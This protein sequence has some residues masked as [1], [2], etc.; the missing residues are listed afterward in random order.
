LELV[1]K[2][3]YLFV[4]FIKFGQSLGDFGNNFHTLPKLG[5]NRLVHIFLRLMHRAVG[6]GNFLI[7]QSAEVLNLV[8][9]HDENI[10]IDFFG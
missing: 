4:G 8:L 2:A 9:K 7:D 5:L 6:I 10:L 3:H 1:G